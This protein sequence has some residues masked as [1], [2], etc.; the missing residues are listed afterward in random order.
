MIIEPATQVRIRFQDCDPFGHLNNARYLDYFI[1]V[2]EDHLRQH[3]QLDLLEFMQRGLGW[4]I[5]QH[6]LLYLKPAHVYETVQMRSSLIDFT[7]HS[8]WVEG[9]M[10]DEEGKQLKTLLWTRYFHVNIKSG[11]KETHTPEMMERFARM[12]NEGI[13]REAGIKGRLAQLMPRVPA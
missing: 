9:S 5:H 7:D 10:W 8:I 12:R 13:S 11:Q 2:R 4:V 6:E 1:N 3:Y